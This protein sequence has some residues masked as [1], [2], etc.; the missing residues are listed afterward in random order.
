MSNLRGKVGSDADFICL[1]SLVGVWMALDKN[2][3]GVAT[4]FFDGELPDAPLQRRE[5]ARSVE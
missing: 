1:R 2:F 3:A 5:G 4:L